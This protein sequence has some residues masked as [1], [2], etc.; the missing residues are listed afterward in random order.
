LTIQTIIKKAIKR[1]E[2]EGK[3]LT[4]DFYAEAFCNEAKKANMSV[5][6]C[7][8]IDKFQKLL[9]KDLQKELSNYR[10]HTLHELIRFLVSKLN[11][12]NKIQCSSMLETQEA[13]VKK[14]LAVISI[15]HDKE[16]SSLAKK[17]LSM[18]DS[19]ATSSEIEQYKQLWVNFQ[20]NY[21][22][23]FLQTLGEFGKVD[24]TDLKKTISNLQF[25]KQEPINK[26]LH[27]VDYKK[28]SSLLIASL[29]PSIASSVD[30]KI[31]G[32][33]SKIRKNPDILENKD[34]EKEIKTAIGLRIALDKESVKNMVSSLD[35]VLDKL[36]VRLI[37]VI[38][39][40]DSSNVD[41]KK[42]KVELDKY[43]ESELNNFK[44]VHE[45]LYTIATAL[46][47]NTQNLTDDLKTHSSEVNALALRVK[48]L[49]GELEK[50]REESKED[51][52]TKLYN[53]RALDEFMKIKESEFTR[54]DH[55]YSIIMFDLDLFKK[56][57]DTYGHDAGDAVLSAF[58]KILKSASREVDI[59]GRF[60]GEEFMAILSETGSKGGA[61]FA[62]KVR[63]HVEKARF[64]YK[65][66]RI[67]VTVSCG[68]SERKLHTSLQ[69]TINS[70]DEYLYQ[71]KKNG[72][73]Q[74]A[75][76]K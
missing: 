11:R 16:A 23:S 34:I 51:F 40:S 61:V 68:V 49:E 15:L 56:V 59:V 50:V 5:E 30:D 39:R 64:M 7:N 62:E 35:T 54:Y 57:N 41:V 75:Y 70:S 21:D 27:S 24:A 14:V 60:G 48:E 8:H 36:S 71:A 13:L 45:K 31:A 72:R 9:N 25:D 63:R 52:L 33:S 1:L 43:N 46:E 19:N 38:E 55:N 69:S 76:K 22:D 53:K 18:L 20:S 67:G 28:I 4:P 66:T 73:N 37:D 47:K 44:L 65:D 58:A 10:I 2:L 29:V 6:D 17:T 32:L 74:V 42:I 12:A 26:P 3:L